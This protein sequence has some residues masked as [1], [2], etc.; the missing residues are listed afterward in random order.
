LDAQIAD[1]I[2]PF[3]LWWVNVI[4]V[5]TGFCVA[6]F[7]LCRREGDA[8]RRISAGIDFF[9]TCFSC[10]S[11]IGALIVFGDLAYKGYL[12][13]NTKHYRIA[14]DKLAQIDGKKLVLLNCPNGKPVADK[15]L[16]LIPGQVLVDSP[17]L[18]ASQ[19]LYWRTQVDRHNAEIANAC[20]SR[21]RLFETRDYTWTNNSSIT[22]SC[23]SANAEGSACTKAICSQER[24]TTSILIAATDSTAGIPLTEDATLSAYRSKVKL[25]GEIPMKALYEATHPI[26]YTFVF[27][28]YIPF[29]AFAFGVRLARPVVE[30]LDPTGRAKFCFFWRTKKPEAREPS[31]IHTQG[32]VEAQV[33]GSEEA[34]VAS[35]A[36][37]SLTDVVTA[38]AKPTDDQTKSD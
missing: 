19:I 22:A 16:G 23:S 34:S 10:V 13:L 24:A 20:Q 9:W 5:L 28:I 21:D 37:T 8:R 4:A 12:D 18:R 33:S 35:I 32:H 2:L 26:Q 29:W 31:A 25:T 1:A 3:T 14:W 15:Q 7:F 17:C 27:F 30:I 36:P 11:I 6:L 38:S